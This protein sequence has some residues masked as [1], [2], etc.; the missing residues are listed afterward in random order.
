ML[1]RFSIMLIFTAVVWPTWAACAAESPDASADKPGDRG[2]ALL[3][4]AGHN[5]ACPA[6][7]HI[8]YYPRKGFA[9]RM[10]KGRFTGSNAGKT[11][12]FQTIAEVKDLPLE[13]QWTEI[14]LEKPTRFRY[15]KFESP[16]GGW[17]NLAE[18]EFYSGDRM[19]PGELFGTAGARDHLDND[20]SK[21]LDGN[22]E[23]YFD[24]VE[25]NNQYVGIDLGPQ[26]QAAAPEFSPRPGAYPAPQEVTITSATPGAKFRV[27]RDGGTPSREWGGEYKEPIKVEKGAVL[28]AVA[29]TD[30]LAASPPVIAPYRIG[31]TARDEKA[32]RTFHIGN[33]LTD[34]VVG[35]LQ[36]VAESA[37]RT[38][39]FHRFTIPGAPT[40]WLWN[41]PGGGFGD[42]RYP[43]AFF[44]LAPID[45]IFTQPFHGH[46]RS[47]PNEVE[48]SGKFFDLCRKH[49]PDVQAWLYVQWP[50]PQFQDRWSQGEGATVDLKLQPAKN[51]QEGVA[52]HVA[53]TEA[54]AERLNK[55][56][57]G[58]PVRIVPGGTALAMLK[59]EVDAGRVPGMKDFFAETFAD[60]IHLTPKG[61]YLI[62]LV[63]YACIYRESPE[64]KVSSLAT[65]LAADQAAVFHRIAWDAVKSYKWAGVAAASQ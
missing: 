3:S 51:W 2:Q 49:S 63:H 27:V 37:G 6:L 23:T 62:S 60:G 12:D 38:L 40:D 35:W 46:D 29:Y 42:C 34:T 5:A 10:L 58:K 52:N 17:G 4:G 8:R 7:T 53:Y 64:G 22:V 31:Q 25:P 18:V 39:D 33:S 56:R 20:F 45:H 47:I 14:R 61:R 43:E 55:T 48:F 41:H 19:I 44:V 16:M 30:E 26:A 57:Q 1:R 21:A 50:G 13:G 65:G 28:V 59:T 9:Q 11:T 54:V 36:P 32:V 24:G 15:L